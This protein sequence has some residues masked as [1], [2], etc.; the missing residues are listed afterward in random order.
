ME[1][2]VSISGK[3]DLPRRK[4]GARSAAAAALSRRRLFAA[5]ATGLVG[6]GALAGLSFIDSR[7]DNSGPVIAVLPGDSLPAEA[8][9]A[10]VAEASSAAPVPVE[11][12]AAPAAIPA[13]GAPAP[14]DA[15]LR[16]TQKGNP[17]AAVTVLD[18]SSYTCS[19]CRGFAMDTEPIVDKLYVATGL[20][21][22]EF[23]HSPLDNNAARAS[24]A[25]EAAGALGDFWGYHHRLMDLQPLLFRS[26]YSDADL[27]AIAEGLGL[28]TDAFTT[29][30]QSERHRS[31]IDADIQDAI[32]RGVSSVP[33]FFVNKEMIVGNQG[34]EVLDT[35]AA[36]VAIS[37]NDS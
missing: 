24:E 13:A 21:L 7:Q 37:R 16:A 33:T 18:F 32:G 23:R 2:P 10:P 15:G 27:I 26:G 36:Q 1:T 19:H 34:Q 22:F 20:I 17:D 8:E 6:G 4:R 3:F 14:R 30:L 28:D 29:E 31:R 11:A 35:I 9:I 5:T 12:I 25:A